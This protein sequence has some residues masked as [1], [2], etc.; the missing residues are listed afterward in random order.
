M[1]DLRH[2][3]VVRLPQKISAVNNLWHSLENGPWDAQVLSQVYRLVHNLAGSGKSYGCPMLGRQAEYAEQLI[4]PLLNQVRAP[5]T[6]VI[7]QIAIALRQLQSTTSIDA[8]VR[9]PLL[10]KADYSY[11][12]LIVDDDVW[13]AKYHASLLEEA[14]MSVQT[15][16]DPEQILSVL[17][18]TNPDLI[19]LDMHMPNR[20]GLEVISLLRAQDSLAGLPIVFLSAENRPNQQLALQT[21][22]DDFLMKPV[23]PARLLSSVISRAKR[24]RIVRARMMQDS[25]TGL[26][27]HAAIKA[28]LEAEVAR[29]ARHQT[30]LAFAIIDIDHF[31]NINDTYGHPVGDRVIKSLSELF[32]NRLRQSTVLGRYGG[33]EFAIIF[34]NCTVADAAKI[35]EDLRKDCAKLEQWSDQGTFQVTFSAGVAACLVGMDAAQLI[36]AAD[37]NLYAAKHHGRNQVAV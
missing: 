33:E 6:Q 17:A 14:G 19:L 30:A 35:L 24:G 27:H 34:E 31:K 29:A 37:Q 5:E 28:R 21:D 32:Q 3:Y 18:D 7:I 8:P 4:H 2:D 1:E 9:I 23:D 25:L 22:G 36:K 10:I 12:V 11:R 13:V 20:S 15:L 26:L 16:N